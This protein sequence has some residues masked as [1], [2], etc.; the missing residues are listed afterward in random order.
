MW[1]MWM[2]PR[3][4]NILSYSTTLIS[5]DWDGWGQHCPVQHGNGNKLSFFFQQAFTIM[6]QNR[7]GFIDKADLRD[8]FAAL[9]K[10]IAIIKYFKETQFKFQARKESLF[11]N[12]S[13]GSNE[14]HGRQK[15]TCSV[16]SF[17]FIV[18]ALSLQ[19]SSWKIFWAAS[20]RSEM[21]VPLGRTDGCTRAVQLAAL[22]RH[23]SLPCNC[24]IKSPPKQGSMPGISDL[25]PNPGLTGCTFFI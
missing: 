12:Y 21:K 6:D 15:E 22:Q 25:P 2:N 18:A 24:F 20:F 3:K 8:T 1:M 4:L 16:R 11:Y 17:S 23:R 10:L 14:I 13:G 9:G 7:D 19:S 5:P